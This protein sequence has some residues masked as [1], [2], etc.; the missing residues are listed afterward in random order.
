MTGSLVAPQLTWSRCQGDE[1][2]PLVCAAR[3]GHVEAVQWL[4]QRGASV[5]AADEVRHTHHSPP[6]QKQPPFTH[7][8][9]QTRSTALHYAAQRAAVDLMPVLVGSGAS[10]EATNKVCGH[11]GTNQATHAQPQ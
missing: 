9:K 5:N 11:M 4:L 10:L 7:P 6:A 8:H 1:G 3:E 2:T